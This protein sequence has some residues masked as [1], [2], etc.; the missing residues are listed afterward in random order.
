MIISMLEE[1]RVWR[2]TVGFG[3]SGISGASAMEIVFEAVVDVLL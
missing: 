1:R 3:C 2:E